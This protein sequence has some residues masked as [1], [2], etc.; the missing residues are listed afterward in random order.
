MKREWP[1]A[2]C[3]GAAFSPSMGLA[4]IGADAGAEAQR[5]GQ[6]G[7]AF[8]ELLQVRRPNCGVGTDIDAFLIEAAS[9]A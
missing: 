9:T 1:R 5:N 4:P 6:L 2:V 7:G 3:Q 8:C